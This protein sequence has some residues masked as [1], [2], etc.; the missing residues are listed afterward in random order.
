MI[1]E[2]KINEKKTLKKK[3]PK[4]ISRVAKAVAEG[5][6]VLGTIGM[7]GCATA[8]KGTTYSEKSIIKQAV[9]MEKTQD[10]RRIIKEISM[11]QS[12]DKEYFKKE[13]NAELITKKVLDI[14]LLIEFTCDGPQDDLYA[15]LI[16]DFHDKDRA[17]RVLTAVHVDGIRELVNRM[18]NGEHVNAHRNELNEMINYIFERKEATENIDNECEARYFYYDEEDLAFLSDYVYAWKPW[19][20]PGAS[21][22]EI[23]EVYGL[24]NGKSH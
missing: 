21:E 17:L 3:K 13:D 7:L 24:C 20:P 4:K 12:Q 15:I 14:F 19:I 6:M 9:T 18:K 11:S 10:L 16:R 22:E 23:H 2:F 1:K 8:N 5:L